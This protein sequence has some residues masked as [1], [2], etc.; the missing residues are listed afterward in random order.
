M[1][2]KAAVSESAFSSS[3]KRDIHLK[4]SRPHAA[5]TPH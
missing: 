3:Y 2:P 1:L 5:N 4:D